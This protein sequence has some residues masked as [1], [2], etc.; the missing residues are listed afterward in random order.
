MC[1]CACGAGR[2][3]SGGTL[4]FVCYI[5]WAPAFSVYPQKIFRSGVGGGGGEGGVVTSYICNS[6]DVLAEWPLFQ[7]CQVYD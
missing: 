1:F 5:G 3:P 6:T 4:N 2:E 7:H